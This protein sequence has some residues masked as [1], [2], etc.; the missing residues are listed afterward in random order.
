MEMLIRTGLGAVRDSRL[1]EGDTTVADLIYFFF[2]N[3]RMEACKIL[4]S[5]DQT[6][7][8]GIV[9]DQANTLQA[10]SLGSLQ[11]SLCV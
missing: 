9:G 7:C 5:R 10:F 11:V 3:C 8:A 6:V 1:G 4:L 2:A